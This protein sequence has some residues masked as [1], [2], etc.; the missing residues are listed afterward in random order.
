MIGT[1][2]AYVLVQE[3][4]FKHS[5]LL[6][7]FCYYIK[8]CCSLPFMFLKVLFYSLRPC[9]SR[10]SYSLPSKSTLEGQKYGHKIR[11]RRRYDDKE[12]FCGNPGSIGEF[13][14]E[15]NN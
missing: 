1:S 6:V 11:R 2:K 3:E 9:P 14:R 7:E 12:E 13:T 4:K 15:S 5:H 8:P 10:L